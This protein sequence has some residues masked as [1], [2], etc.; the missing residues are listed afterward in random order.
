MAKR[1]ANWP[2]R[3]AGVVRLSLFHM[4]HDIDAGRLV[5][6]LAEFNS[7]EVE[8][9]HAVYIGRAGTMPARVRTVLGFLVACSGVAGG[10]YTLKRSTP[11]PGNA[12]VT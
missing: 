1:C 9:I 2:L 3:G 5:P 8:S 12:A 6:L 11:T 10:R 4:R 7:C